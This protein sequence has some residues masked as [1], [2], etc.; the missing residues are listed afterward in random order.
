MKPTFV[1]RGA[2]GSRG[3]DARPQPWGAR[4]W[5]RSP[6]SQLSKFPLKQEEEEG[7]GEK[8]LALSGQRTWG[9][10]IIPVDVWLHKWNGEH[11]FVSRLCVVAAPSLSFQVRTA[12]GGG[13]QTAQH[14][15]RTQPRGRP[16]ANSMAGA[17]GCAASCLSACRRSTDN[18]LGTFF[19]SLF[20]LRLVCLIRNKFSSKKNPFC[21]FCT[22][23]ERVCLWILFKA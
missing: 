13:A 17:A 2:P 18:N 12:G 1:S 15:A 22:S 23:G 6:R 16:G 19:Y 20:K 14:S 4:G 11:L 3:S 7:G 5:R 10:D 9:K 8:A 21:S